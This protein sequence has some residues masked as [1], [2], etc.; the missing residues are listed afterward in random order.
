MS[1]ST[2]TSRDVRVDCYV[3]DG[4]RRS[5]PYPEESVWD[6]VRRGAF[7]CAARIE[8][9]VRETVTTVFVDVITCTSPEL[10]TESYVA[11]SSHGL[12]RNCGAGIVD[13]YENPASPIRHWIH[14]RDTYEEDST[15]HA[16]T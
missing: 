9:T 6:V 11:H 16:T 14:E 13:S 2:S 1:I 5:G 3:V 4:D 7:G 15:W 12:C 10:D 8:R